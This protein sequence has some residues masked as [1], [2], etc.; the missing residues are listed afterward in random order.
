MLNF[1]CDVKGEVWMQFEHIKYTTNRK[2]I[3]WVLGKIPL[4]ISHEIVILKS[5]HFTEKLIFVKIFCGFMELQ[6]KKMTV[7]LET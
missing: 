5:Y 2:K 6:I 3:I 1:K 7:N 4:A